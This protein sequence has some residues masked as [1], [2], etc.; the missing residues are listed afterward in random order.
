MRGYININLYS[1]MKFTYPYKVWL[2][3]IVGAPLVL[4][5][6]LGIY[7]SGSITGLVESLPLILVMIVFGLGVSLPSLWLYQLL[8]KE[9]KDNA[10]KTGLKKLVLALV[11]IS[12]IWISFYL[13]DR[14]YFKDP[15][16][17]S[18]AWPGIYTVVL[19]LSAFI[20]RIDER[21]VT[22]L[23]GKQPII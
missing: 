10:I 14:D 22:D 19:L 15:D 20:F 13:I 5:V 7:D 8:F 17:N 12:F 4:M 3:T 11:G 21:R 1:E 16:F 6:C 23:H 9:I 18:L 2:S